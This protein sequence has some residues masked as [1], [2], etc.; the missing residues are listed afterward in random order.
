[1]FA[2]DKEMMEWP[3]T[4]RLGLSGV[5]TVW[6]YSAARVAELVI[7]VRPRSGRGQIKR[8]KLLVYVFRLYLFSDK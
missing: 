1:M 2:L 4:S 3:A 8:K 7:K 6:F 5:A